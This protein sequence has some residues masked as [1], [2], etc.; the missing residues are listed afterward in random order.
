[1]RAREKMTVGVTAVLEGD[2]ALR[3]KLRRV[4]SATKEKII[5]RAVKSAL[6]PIKKAVKRRMPVGT[7]SRRPGHTPGDLRR[8]IE[9]KVKTYRGSGNVW[10]GVGPKKGA[11]DEPGLR[12]HW[13]EFGRPAHNV[14]AQAPLRK[15]LQEAKGEA[16]RVLRKRAWDGIKREGTR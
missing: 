16:Q 9:A 1:M 14:P 6:L 13:V 8:S 3:R 4:A 12:V 2:E 5:P 15:G 10:G 7:R 11:P